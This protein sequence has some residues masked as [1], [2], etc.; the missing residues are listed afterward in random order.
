[1][2]DVAKFTYDMQFDLVQLFWLFDSVVTCL[3]QQLASHGLFNV[4]VKATGDIHIDDH[5]TNE[6][7]ALAMGTVVKKI[8]ILII[9]DYDIFF[10]YSSCSF[11]R[12]K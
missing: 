6:D 5:H 2:V 1:M 11:L 3:F 9:T 8:I 12:N 4:N 7:I 10:F